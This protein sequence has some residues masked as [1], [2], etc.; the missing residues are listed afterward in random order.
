MTTT[1]RDIARAIHREVPSISIAEGVRL[2]DAV[3]AAVKDG[4]LHEGKVMVTNFGSFEAVD[5][6]ARRG[7]SPASG[8]PVVIP[9]HRAVVFRPAPA[10]QRAV[11]E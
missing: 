1:K 9:S 8:E 3:I 6:A 4:V 11:D 5:R 10:L 2:V 7:V